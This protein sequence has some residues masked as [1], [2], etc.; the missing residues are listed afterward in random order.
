[1]TFSKRLRRTGART[2]VLAALLVLVLV[3]ASGGP[4]HAA[5]VLSGSIEDV[6]TVIPADCPG[7]SPAEM[8]ELE[9]GMGLALSALQGAVTNPFGK[10][11]L[12]QGSLA[13]DVALATFDLYRSGQ[14]TSTQWRTLA[15]EKGRFAGT[16]AETSVD[17]LMG[18]YRDRFADALDDAIPAGSYAE[19]QM[20]IYT[21]VQL[22]RVFMATAQGVWSPQEWADRLSAGESRHGEVIRAVMGL[23]GG[24]RDLLDRTVLTSKPQLRWLEAELW[25]LTRLPEPFRAGGVPAQ[26]EALRGQYETTLRNSWASTMFDG[27]GLEASTV[28]LAKAAERSL[29]VSVIS[30][31]GPLYTKEFG[32][33]EGETEAENKIEVDGGSITV[34]GKDP[35]GRILIILNRY[36]PNR[37]GPVRPEGSGIGQGLG[38]GVGPILPACPPERLAMFMRPFYAT[39]D[40][41]PGPP[42]GCR[43]PQATKDELKDGGCN[44]EGGPE[45]LVGPPGPGGVAPPLNPG[46]QGFQLPGVIS[47]PAI[48]RIVCDLTGGRGPDYEISFTIGVGG[49]LS[50]GVG[51]SGNVETSG[52][53]IC[54][55][56]RID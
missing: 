26:V 8:A 36:Q 12:A 31:A 49:E 48:C 25:P 3:G 13:R 40:C 15:T 51:A 1:M 50:I 43:L 41:P 56:D 39:G 20:A 21:G 7:C 32:D 45:I 38:P 14:V 54:K 10:P 30:N 55:G 27:C 46:G 34:I 11:C 37:P 52:T 42:A 28:F 22:S 35:W 6:F 9:V 24:G 17:S 23:T 16:V 44:P 18:S 47:V 5:P 19:Q 2:L 29:G 53:C 4:L 33:G